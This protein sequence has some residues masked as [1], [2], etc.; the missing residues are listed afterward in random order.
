MNKIIS[1]YNSELWVLGRLAPQIE[2]I[3]V[4]ESIK[5]LDMSEMI[6]YKK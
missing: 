4:P 6:D 5:F 1:K 2:H 3:I